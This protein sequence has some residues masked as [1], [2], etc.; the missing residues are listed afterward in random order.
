MADFR[1]YLDKV[2]VPY[3]DADIAANLDWIKRKIK[4]R[5]VSVEFG[6]NAGYKVELENDPQ[7]DRA[8]ESLPQARVLYENVRRIIA[9]RTTEDPGQ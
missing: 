7:V 9:Q 3:T 6:L 5:S 2:S 1:E 4:E 8:I